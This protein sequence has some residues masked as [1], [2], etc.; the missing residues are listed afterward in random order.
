MI[1]DVLFNLFQFACSHF[2]AS[3]QTSSGQWVRFGSSSLKPLGSMRKFCMFRV[4]RMLMCYTSMFLSS[5][6]MRRRQNINPPITSNSRLSVR[7]PTDMV[8]W[9]SCGHGGCLRP[10]TGWWNGLRHWVSFPHISAYYIHIEFI[11]HSYFIHITPILHSDYHISEVW[12]TLKLFW[13]P[14]NNHT[15][16]CEQNISQGQKGSFACCT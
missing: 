11:L 13:W 12:F 14:R 16:Q 15:F 8:P 7:Q 2:G 6:Q 4:P 3:L 10:P 1:W 9:C 5:L